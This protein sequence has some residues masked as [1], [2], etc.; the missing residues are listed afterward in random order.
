MKSVL[1]TGATGFVGRPCIP[2]LVAAGYEVHAVSTQEAPHDETLPQV[3]WHRADLLDPSQIAPLMAK[4][5]PTHLLHLA[6]CYTRPGQFWAD[7][8]NF[9][10]VQASLALLQEFAA[11]GGKRVVMAGTCAEYDWDF[12]YCSE[13]HT[14]LRPTT[15]YGTCKHSMQLLLDAFASHTGISAAWGRLFFLYGPGEYSGRLVASVINS[16]LKGEPA[17]CSHGEQVRDFLYSEDA[18]AAFVAL[19]ESELQGP[20]NIASGEGTKI[21]DVVL[22]IGEIMQRPELIQLGAL[23]SSPSEPRVLIGHNERLQSET[24]W[25][26][27]QSLHAGLEQSIE[28][29]K[30]V[31]K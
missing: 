2:F 21:K 26:Q 4:V 9:R 19:L 14:P 18:A 24:S 3:H 30:S 17:L 8:D 22:R 13:A 27:A 23:P 11:I 28:W 10:W 5:Q 12:G 31:Q 29:W 7:A 20:I 25:R 16:L 6:W 15:L 1:L